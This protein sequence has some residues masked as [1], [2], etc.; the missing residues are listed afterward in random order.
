MYFDF[1]GTHKVEN[2]EFD[3]RKNKAGVTLEQIFN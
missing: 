1:D 2:N 3:K